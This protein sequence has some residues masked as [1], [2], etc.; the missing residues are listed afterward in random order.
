[1]RRTLVRR[2]GPKLEERL[3]ALDEALE[4]A[5]GRLDAGD[6]ADGRALVARAGRRLRLGPELTV[7]ALAGATGSGKSSL[8]NAVAGEELSPVGVRRPTTGNA[9]ACVWGEAEDAD[10]LLDW[11]SVPKRHR[12]GAEDREFEG[13]VLL[14]LPDHDS[15]Q[16]GHRL[17]AERLV[18]LVDLMVWVLDPQKYA[19][20]ALHHR[21]LRPLAGHASVIL[22]VF[23]HMDRLDE[24][25][26]RACLADARRLLEQDGMRDVPILATSARTGEG[27]GELR[28]RLTQ[29][30]AERRA[31]V[32]R[33]TAD[34]IVVATR[35]RSAC[36]GGNAPRPSGRDRDRLV[37][38]LMRAAG[39]DLVAETVGRAQLHR[40]RL[41]TGWPYSRWLRRLR[42][43]P[44]ARLHVGRVARDDEEGHVPRTS[45]PPATPVQRATAASAVR[46]IA[47]TAADPLRPAWAAAV[48][49]SVLDREEDLPDRLD[50]AV[51][52][53]E[54][55]S[56]RR[57]R[58]W[59]A[60][61]ALQWL[62]A[63][64]AAA[65]AVWLLALW[66]LSW[67]RLPEPPL[68]EIRQVPLPTAM[69]IGGILAGPILAVV[70]AQF[71]KVGATR[72]RISA[73]R[74]LREQVA[75]V[76]DEEVMEPLERE[77][78]TYERF[79]VLTARAAGDS[80]G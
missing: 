69:L 25:A 72:R 21:Y 3:L 79:C 10:T 1:V 38:A 66:V 61:G 77:L 5:D 43:D 62:L 76:A 15:I 44:L 12:R 50:R 13:M 11:L 54:L 42:P 70:S 55:E 35:L 24:D 53:A 32:E 8:F 58:W 30:V 31:A 18:Q 73:R 56:D 52:R 27:V 23:N 34:V 26:R 40:A 33:L 37:E 4:L 71:A 22:L 29:R 16:V 47:S 7:V 51:G 46:R 28:A 2:S 14:D 48:R 59:R 17:E 63:L 19:D 41:A 9:H 39:A 67:F 49:R 75:R 60:V 65:G 6:V 68:P 57:P 80:R 45:L 36:A 74:T 78:A 20:A 64:V